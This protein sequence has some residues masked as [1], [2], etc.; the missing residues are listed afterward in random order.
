MSLINHPFAKNTNDTEDEKIA[1]K[2]QLEWEIERYA[3]ALKG[4]D[5]SSYYFQ[6]CDLD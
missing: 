6:T 2:N 5:V 4:I 3:F 1:F